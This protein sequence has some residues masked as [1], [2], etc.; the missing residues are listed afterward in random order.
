MA[1]HLGDSPVRPTDGIVNLPV[2]VGPGPD[3]GPN[4]IDEMERHFDERRYSFTR[5]LLLAIEKEQLIDLVEALQ[6]QTTI[7]IPSPRFPIPSFPGLPFPGIRPFASIASSHVGTRVNPIH[8]ASGQARVETA[9]MEEMTVRV[10]DRMLDALTAKI[11]VRNRPADVAAITDIVEHTFNVI[12][13][14]LR[15]SPPVD[16]AS[17][18]DTA[19][20]SV[21]I[22]K[23]ALIS[24]A[25]LSD[26]QATDVLKTTKLSEELT[27]SLT[28]AIK[29]PGI[30][31]I[32]VHLSE[33]IETEPLAITGNTLVFR[34]KKVTDAEVLKNDLVKGKLK[35]LVDQPSSV[36]GFVIA[37]KKESTNHDV[38]LPTTGVFAEAILG[39]AN[40]S[41]KIDITRF[42]NWQDSPIPHLAPRI[43]DLQA[44]G[45][46]QPPLETG[47]PTV[48]ASVV[49]IVNPLAFPDPSGLAAS[50]AAVQNGNLFRDM[51]KTEALAGVLANLSNLANQQG[52]LA[53]TL[54]G[55]AQKEALE[56][57]VSFGNKV[58]DMTAQALQAQQQP[59]APQTPT[60][61]GGALNEIGKLIQ[62][63][64]RSLSDSGAAP[65]TS[66]VADDPRARVAGVP[67]P[68]VTPD[69][70]RNYT[71]A[72][73]FLDEQGRG[74]PEGTFTLTMDF[75]ESGST[76]EFNGNA[77][78]DIS[79]GRFF[80]DL[81]TFESGRKAIISISAN[82]ASTIIDGVKEFTLPDHPDIVF[83][84]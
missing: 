39:R 19:K 61:K 54:A 48:P 40:A 53:G 7:K 6:F 23:N 50:L 74:Y 81:G 69:R 42:F 4:A 3:A 71:M 37:S 14:E 83:P 56:A 64:Q 63:Q 29:I 67:P 30:L 20:L 1:Y 41:E 82:M 79:R 57:A 32:N 2:K 75:F 10:R 22:V 68:P 13:S 9:A 59:S 78:I 45:R 47:G 25:G 18:T 34:M 26:R 65:S 8:F 44:G 21:E 5:L 12:R 17:I 52:Q 76:V 28:A 46:D 35:P 55:N 36:Q 24:T 58:A 70:T 16:A 11:P 51:S 66:D 80:S 33:F 27:S 31:V 73:I 38:H 60:E 84:D 62:E 15:R 72:I 77:P 49:N 43:A